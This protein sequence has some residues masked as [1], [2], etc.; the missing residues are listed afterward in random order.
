MMKK[1]KAIIATIISLIVLLLF[2]LL[3]FI[4]INK[5]NSVSVVL[6]RFPISFDA[7]TTVDYY[8][9]L[10]NEQ[11]YANLFKQERHGFLGDIGKSWA[12]INDSTMIISLHENV[13]FH[14]GDPIRAADV[15]A[16]IDRATSHHKS[17]YYYLFGQIKVSVIDEHT[18]E[19][20]RQNDIDLLSFLIF[21]PIYSEKQIDM[22]DTKFNPCN[23]L[24]SGDYYVHSYTDSIISLKRNKY[25]VKSS[26]KLFNEI[27]LYKQT[28]QKKACNLLINNKVDFVLEPGTDC[29]TKIND[30]SNLIIKSKPSDLTVYLM[31][32]IMSPTLSKTHDRPNPLKD[33]NVRRAI[34]Q[35]LDVDTFIKEKRHGFGKKLTYPWLPYLRGANSQLRTPEYDIEKSKMLLS[36]AGYA[37]GFTINLLCP[38]TDNIGNSEVARFINSSLYEI[39]ITVDI[40]Y[41]NADEMMDYLKNNKVDAYLG[42]YITDSDTMVGLVFALFYKD[43]YRVG[44]FNKFNIEIPYLI[45][46]LQQIEMGLPSSPEIPELTKEI[47]EYIYN[48]TLIIPLYSSTNNYAYNKKVYFD[49]AVIGFKLSDLKRK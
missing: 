20:Q 9:D 47:S 32:D 38:L 2:V 22:L 36:K 25:R 5:K 31:L 12:N 11:L 39:G 23:I 48:E 18:V 13:Y 24:S 7:L 1:K 33:K 19:L 6:R 21:I 28:D 14:N 45:K 44:A 3:S 26:D 15:K 16:S 43:E 42:G 8:T 29:L 4:A 46:S 10:V 35:A 27:V 37:Q 49:N 17:R 40:S 30:Q 41:V 34:W